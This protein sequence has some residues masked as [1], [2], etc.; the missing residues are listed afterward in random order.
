M[1]LLLTLSMFRALF[2]V[3][4]VDFEQ[5]NA[6]WELG[7]QKKLEIVGSNTKTVSEICTSNRMVS[8]AIN[9]KFDKW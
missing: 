4:T 8:S 6:R 1:S 5:V 2:N 7:K 9:D 3:S